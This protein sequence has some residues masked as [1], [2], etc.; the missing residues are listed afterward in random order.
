[1]LYNFYRKEHL[2]N[3]VKAEDCRCD[4][5]VQDCQALTNKSAHVITEMTLLRVCQILGYDNIHFLL[6]E[7]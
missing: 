5:H 3:I 6:K 4:Y 2:G 7:G 1:M